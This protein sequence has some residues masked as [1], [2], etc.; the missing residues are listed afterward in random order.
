MHL[1]GGDIYKICKKSYLERCEGEKASLV[2]FLQNNFKMFSSVEL[3]KVKEISTK[4]FP[5]EYK[6]G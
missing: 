2:H 4:L 5:V 1:A 3:E 6:P